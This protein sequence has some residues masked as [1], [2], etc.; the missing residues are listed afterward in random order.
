MADSNVYVARRRVTITTEQSDII[1]IAFLEAR[2]GRNFKLEYSMMID[3]SDL[4]QTSTA[5]LVIAWIDFDDK[6][7]HHPDLTI[8][9]S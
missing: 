8:A 1:M 2:D 6:E 3:K 5:L 7:M 9:N 4:N